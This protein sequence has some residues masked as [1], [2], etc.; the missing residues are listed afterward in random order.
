MYTTN[1][2]EQLDHIK[3]YDPEIGR[4]ISPDNTKYLEPAILGGLNL[5]AYCRNNPVMYFD[6]TGRFLIGLL[7]TI[8]GGIWAYSN[9]DKISED[10]S[11]FKWDNKSKKK[12]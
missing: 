5:Y 9:W 4:F 12:L 11:N 7:P 3:L 10:I 8:L 6:P 2:L 1:R